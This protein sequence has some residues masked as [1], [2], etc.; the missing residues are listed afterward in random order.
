MSSL[1][2]LNL[3]LNALLQYQACEHRWI[4]KERKGGK[5]LSFTWKMIWTNSFYPNLGI[6]PISSKPN[7]H[8]PYYHIDTIHS[9]KEGKLLRRPTNKETYNKFYFTI[10]YYRDCS[11][12]IKFQV[13]SERPLG[14]WLPSLLPCLNYCKIARILYQVEGGSNNPMM[15]L[16]I[17][18]V[19]VLYIIA[20]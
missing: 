12:S 4:T 14:G 9:K 16:L 1:K 11:N 20:I 17:L 3:T 7:F 8:I 15:S 18:S 10:L 19:I 5:C 13:G 2:V 6:M